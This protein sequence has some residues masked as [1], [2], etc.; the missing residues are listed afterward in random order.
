MRFSS[1]LQNFIDKYQSCHNIHFFNYQARY[2]NKL[3]LKIDRKE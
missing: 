1:Y 3:V 2:M